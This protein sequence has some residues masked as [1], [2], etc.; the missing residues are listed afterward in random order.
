MLFL[1]CG[2]DRYALPAAAV[3]EVVPA[4][5]LHRPAGDA[6]PAFAGVL[7]YRGA[8]VPVLALA[9]AGP[10]RLGGRIV[11]VGLPGD[12]PR[13]LGLLADG[14]SEL[15]PLEA[16]GVAFAPPADAAGPDLGALVAVAGG[17]VRLL[18]PA[19]L[20]ASLSARPRAI[21]ATA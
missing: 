17:L 8:V 12:P 3:E 16:T 2:A 18:D 21:G 5:P 14:V 9:A 1:H 7:R 13:R 15:K 20:L 4:V 10:P 19:A 11:V 6:H